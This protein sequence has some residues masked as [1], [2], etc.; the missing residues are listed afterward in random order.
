MT[1][2]ACL[3]PSIRDRG[4]VEQR[5]RRKEDQRDVFISD[6]LGRQYTLV[7]ITKISKLNLNI[8]QQLSEDSL[9]T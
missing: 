2:G 5:E 1:L 9:H 8:Q 4:G 6:K 7:W 3:L